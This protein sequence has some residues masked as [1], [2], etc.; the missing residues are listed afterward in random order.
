LFAFVMGAEFFVNLFTS[1]KTF[2]DA[3]PIMDTRFA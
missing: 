1:A 3:V 2:I